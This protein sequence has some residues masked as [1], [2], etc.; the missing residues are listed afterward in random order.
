MFALLVK[1]KALAQVNYRK[2]QSDTITDRWFN[3]CTTQVMCVSY[4]KQVRYYRRALI[5]LL[6][7]PWPLS[8]PRRGGALNN[9]PFVKATTNELESEIC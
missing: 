7:A 2:M 3:E 8:G 1:T 5:Q 4:D 6:H 9:G